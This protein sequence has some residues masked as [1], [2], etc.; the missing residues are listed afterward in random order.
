MEEGGICKFFCLKV[1][2]SRWRS[3]R[4]WA[5]YFLSS[6]LCGRPLIDLMR[7]VISLSYFVAVH[8]FT[9]S[10]FN[11]TLGEMPVYDAE[12]T[13]HIYIEGIDSIDIT[14]DPLLLDG[15]RQAREFSS[16]YGMRMLDFSSFSIKQ[17]MYVHISRPTYSAI[18]HM[19]Q[20][21]LSAL[22][23]PPCAP[24]SSVCTCGPSVWPII[25][26]SYPCPLFVS[27]TL[28]TVLVTP[29]VCLVMF[30]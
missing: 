17:C 2:K 12:R 13:F 22:M 21:W 29:S 30:L 26:P 28:P 23:G 5:W 4:E 10:S 1:S 8:P 15:P 9:A 14:H 20:A 16:C 27:Y 19:D 6:H 11:G 24:Y 25:L 3:Q 18:S 7:T